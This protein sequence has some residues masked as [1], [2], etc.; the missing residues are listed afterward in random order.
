M[1]SS[2]LLLP[3]ASAPA[4]RR[5]QGGISFPKRMGVYK[6]IPNAVLFAKAR[7][8]RDKARPRKQQREE[9]HN[10]AAEKKKKKENGH[11]RTQETRT[12]DSG[13]VFIPAVPA[14]TSPSSSGYLTEGPSL[15]MVLSNL[16]IGY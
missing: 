5:R 11:Q 12:S 4:G 14:Y 2:A 8:A 6:C 9:E 16:H 3:T 13:S 1:V 10:D 7:D 15:S